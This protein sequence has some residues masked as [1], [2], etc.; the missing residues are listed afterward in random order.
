MDIY[1]LRTTEGHELK[2]MG[3]GSEDITQ[4]WA[5]I[6]NALHKLVEV[7]KVPGRKAKCKLQHLSAR[8]LTQVLYSLRPK[9]LPHDG[10]QASVN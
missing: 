10:F 1:K 3:P 6:L 7:T 5:P 8:V 4:D 9:L 2:D